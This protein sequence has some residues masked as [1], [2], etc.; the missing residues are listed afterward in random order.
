MHFAIFNGFVWISCPKELLC[1]VTTFLRRNDDYV[2]LLI[3]LFPVNY[4]NDGSPGRS[5]NRLLIIFE[6]ADMAESY[7]KPGNQE[8][9]WNDPPQF[10]YGLQV[11]AQGT[12]KR[13]LSKRVPALLEDMPRV[14]VPGTTADSTSSAAS[15]I[16]RPTGSPHAVPLIPVTQPV[17]TCTLPSAPVAAS[18]PVAPPAVKSTAIP[19]SSLTHTANKTD[20]VKQ[21]P[22]S[23]DVNCDVNVMNVLTPLNDALTSCRTTVKK[24]VCDDIG[25]RLNVFQEMWKS[26]KLSAPVMKRMNLLAQELKKQNWD[27]ADEIHRSLMVD[28]INEVCQWMVGVKRLIAEVRNLPSHTSVTD[29]KTHCSHSASGDSLQVL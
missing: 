15:A 17:T 23:E 25:R 29:D 9:G 27:L 2:V 24:Q 22:S 12:P 8:R 11:Q 14:P 13:I 18:G 10:S 16:P 4:G 3:F 21:P 1:R 26:G 28:H 20:P 5:E 19:P 7:V 6:F